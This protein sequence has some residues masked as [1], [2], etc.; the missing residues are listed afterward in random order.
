MTEEG[1]LTDDEQATWRA[2]LASVHLLDAALDRQLRRDAGMPLTYYAI[3][4]ELSEAPDGEVRMSE[5]ADAL[6]YSASRLAHAVGSMEDAGWVRRDPCHTGRGHVAV[7]TPA[8]RQAIGTAAPAHVAEVRRL[9]FDR[10]TPSQVRVLRSVCE[11]LIDGLD[12]ERRAGGRQPAL[13]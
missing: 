6:R 2:Y 10:L 11:S 5:L 13:D 8:G 1:W 3:L 9:V 7:L 4:V 12:E